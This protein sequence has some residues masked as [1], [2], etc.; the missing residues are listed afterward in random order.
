MGWA[1]DGEFDPEEEAAS[2]PEPNA[3]DGAM[4]NAEMQEAQ[5]GRLPD[6]MC[7]DKPPQRSRGC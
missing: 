7:A 3:E 6:S 4:Q 2:T 1:D 5:F